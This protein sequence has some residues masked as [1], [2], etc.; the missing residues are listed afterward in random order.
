MILLTWLLAAALGLSAL[1]GL[2]AAA[3]RVVL[4]EHYTNFR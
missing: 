3:E 4:V 2:L 1:P